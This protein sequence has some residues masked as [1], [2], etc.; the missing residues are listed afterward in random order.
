PRAARGDHAG[1]AL[2]TQQ[3]RQLAE[4]VPRAEAIHE[5]PRS[6]RPDLELPAETDEEG[7]AFVALVADGIAATAGHLDEPLRDRFEVC[8]IEAAEQRHS[9]EHLEAGGGR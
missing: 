3:Q 7:V 1:R 2:S 8:A 4:E 6:A 9:G 5:A